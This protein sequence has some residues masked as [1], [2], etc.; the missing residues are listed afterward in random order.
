MKSV[1]DKI[2]GINGKT[3]KEEKNKEGKNTLLLHLNCR[4]FKIQRE[5]KKTQGSGINVRPMLQALL[6][7]HKGEKS[8]RHIDNRKIL[9]NRLRERYSGRRVKP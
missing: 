8:C 2:Q 9:C 1:P 7:F 5:N 3:Q 6:R 4:I